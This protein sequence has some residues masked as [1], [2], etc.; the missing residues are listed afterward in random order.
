[1]AKTLKLKNNGARPIVLMDGTVLTPGQVTEVNADTAKKLKEGKFGGMDGPSLHDNLL[2]NHDIQL[3]SGSDDGVGDTE[4][5]DAAPLTRSGGGSPGSPSHG[6]G[7][8]AP[9]RQDLPATSKK[10]DK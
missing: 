6:T 8:G 9:S 7:Q 3:V 4:T 2:E 10:Q 5:V 1:M